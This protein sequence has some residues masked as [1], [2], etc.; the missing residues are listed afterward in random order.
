MIDRERAIR[1][2][3]L[4]PFGNKGWMRS[5]T[6]ACPECGK[7]DKFG[8][9]ISDKGGGV[10]CFKCGYSLGIYKYLHLIKRADLI[11][12]Q[13]NVTFGKKLSLNE[14]VEEV[15]KKEVKL[16]SGFKKI[17]YDKYLADRGWI[18]LQYDLY[19]VGVSTSPEL[20]EYLIYPQYDSGEL[21]G[22]FARTRYSKKW[23]EKNIRK[24][25]EEDGRLVLRYKN[26]TNTDFG[27]IIGGIDEIEEDTS[28]II[29]VE[30]LFDKSSVDRELRLYNKP[31]KCLYS[32][33]NNIT[34]E[35]ISRLRRTNIK[36]VILFYDYGTIDQMKSCSLEL[37][38]CFNT[39]V[40]EILEDTDPG[41]MNAQEMLEVFSRLK[42]PIDFFSKRIKLKKNF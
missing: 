34:T 35:Q 21:L 22:W 7:F 4:K 29:I 5:L 15:E 36:N 8:I 26:S 28:H 38:R 1:E 40:A 10:S 33:G 23:H 32:F 16:P 13:Q 31:L 42:S 2:L 14:P 17:Q 20:R 18:P 19:N 6:L 41:D 30:G 39:K 12:G 24:F 25:K 37:G 11:Q 27:H 3:E 9:F